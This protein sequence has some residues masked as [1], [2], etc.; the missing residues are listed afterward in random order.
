MRLTDRIR[1]TIE[2]PEE[3]PEVR[4]TL[5]TLDGLMHAR[6]LALIRQ[7]NDWFEEYSGH[8]LSDMDDWPDDVIEASA[9]ALNFVVTFAQNVASIETV[10]VPTKGGEWRRVPIPPAWQTIDGYR[11][12]I[13]PRLSDLWNA[14]A[15]I[16]NP[17]LWTVDNTDEGKKKDADSEK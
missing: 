10:E 6:Y 2:W 8:R 4:I 1:A 15:L 11:D 17:G 5:A 12:N 14:E 3:K 13:P 9:T 16:V 7:M